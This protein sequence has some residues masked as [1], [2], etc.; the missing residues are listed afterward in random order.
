MCSHMKCLNAGYENCINLPAIRFLLDSLQHASKCQSIDFR[1]VMTT[2]WHPL[3]AT[4][5]VLQCHCSHEIETRKQF[6]QLIDFIQ[7]MWFKN[8]RLHVYE[9]VGTFV[10]RIT[11]NEK[12]T[13]KITF[14]IKFRE[15]TEQFNFKFNLN[16]IGEINWQILSKCVLFF[17]GR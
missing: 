4:R 16:F 15:W 5:N 12:Y 2:I 17:I 10:I 11:V 8:I 6:L 3:T 14:P 9:S 13:H 7:F 1:V